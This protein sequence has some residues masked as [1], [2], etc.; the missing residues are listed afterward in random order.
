MSYAVHVTPE[1][2][3]LLDKVFDKKTELALK[4]GNRR[5][6]DYQLLAEMIEEAAI[7]AGVTDNQVKVTDIPPTNVG[8]TIAE[9]S[10][11]RV[12]LETFL[13]AR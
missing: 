12:C 10:D 13:D 1:T 7:L 2:R 6:F 4:K 8:S 3:Q 9:N 11:Y 5:P